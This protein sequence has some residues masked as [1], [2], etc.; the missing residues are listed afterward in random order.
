MSSVVSNRGVS[1]VAPQGALE[2]AEQK[3]LQRRSV[4]TENAHTST[5]AQAIR[6]LGGHR[7]V[8]GAAASVSV[9]LICITKL[10]IPAVFF[11]LA[12]SRD[13]RVKAG[14]FSNHEKI[15]EKHG[16]NVGNGSPVISE[17]AIW[18]DPERA[19]VQLRFP[20]T[21]IGAACITCVSAEMVQCAV[22]D[23][24]LFYNPARRGFS[25]EPQLT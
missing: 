2:C 3:H 8:P 20:S 22:S 21:R 10:L 7:L 25:A 19:R 5:C 11:Y 14:L 13:S 12:D 9:S 16:V 18:M 6:V 17:H 23:W 15:K 24:V 4:E 1:D